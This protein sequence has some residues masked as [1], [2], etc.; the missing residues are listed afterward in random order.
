[1]CIAQEERFPGN[2]RGTAQTTNILGVPIPMELI[3]G[4]LD[5]YPVE[6]LMMQVV[7]STVFY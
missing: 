4:V 3:P 5:R 1:M 6:Y 2:T 7:Y